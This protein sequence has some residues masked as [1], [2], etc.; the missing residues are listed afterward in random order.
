MRRL[1]FAAGLLLAS[2]PGRLRHIRGG[3]VCRRGWPA[4][5][6]R[7]RPAR[8]SAREARRRVVLAGWYLSAAAL[9]VGSPKDLH[10]RRSRQPV[11]VP[12]LRRGPDRALRRAALQASR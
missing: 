5:R 6:G 9:L 10:H 11:P 12:R 3:Y 4:G 8:I 7:I 1:L 2:A